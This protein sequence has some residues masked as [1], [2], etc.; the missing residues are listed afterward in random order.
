VN[1]RPNESEI[2]ADSLRWLTGWLDLSGP[3]SLLRLLRPDSHFQNH[4]KQQFAQIETNSLFLRHFVCRSTVTM[5]CGE[6]N[7]LS[8]RKMNE[9]QNQNDQLSAEEDDNQSFECIESDGRAFRVSI[10][11]RF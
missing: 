1:E 2:A 10:R 6:G 9:E 4:P 8:N 5:K 7:H 3:Q 11:V